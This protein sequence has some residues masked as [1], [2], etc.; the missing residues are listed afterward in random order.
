[1]PVF[2]VADALGLAVE[3]RSDL[4]QRARLEIWEDEE[5]EIATIA[6]RDSLDRNVSR[7]AVA[8]EIGHAILIRKHPEAAQQWDVKRRFS[9]MR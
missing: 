6:V 5:S 3:K 8:H 1:M 4:R 2:D 7:F 9:T